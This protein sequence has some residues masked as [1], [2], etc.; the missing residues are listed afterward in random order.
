[1]T[2]RVLFQSFQKGNDGSWCTKSQWTLYALV[3]DIPGDGN[4]TQGNE[5]L[6]YMA[7]HPPIG[8]HRYIMLLFQ[9]KGHIGLVEQPMTR[10]NFSTR[11]FA[12]QLDLGVPVSTVYFNA[13]KEPMNR[14]RWAKNAM[15]Y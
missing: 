3:T 11:A 14:K 8:I 6:P 12:H 10:A 9:Q 4:P 13:Q 15:K 1:M 2:K 5:I 7:P